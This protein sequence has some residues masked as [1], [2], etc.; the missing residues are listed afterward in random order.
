MDHRL[1]SG[2][3]DYTRFLVVGAARTG[4]NLVTQSLNAHPEVACFR[5][6]F[7]C[8]P[9]TIEFGQLGYYHKQNAHSMIDLKQNDPLRLVEQEV[10]RLF[11]KQIKA[12]GYKLL[13]NHACEGRM[14]DIR[15]AIKED[16]SLRV[17]HLK[18]RDALA[19]ILSAKL[20]IEQKKWYVTHKEIS[21]FKQKPIRLSVDFCRE[22]FEFIEDKTMEHDELFAQHDVLE[23]EYETLSSEFV[24]TM[25][26]VQE[27]L[28]ITQKPLSQ[29]TKKMTAQS[30]QEL[31]IN[32]DELKSAFAATKWS[33]YFVE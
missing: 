33:M 16:H 8:D 27:F 25:N 4:T 24:K 11:G 14:S 2:H 29:H 10:F 28:G 18:R 19:K 21:L 5:E 3:R 31:I 20:A 22:R 1:R 17:I 6:I 12:V 9:Q 26:Q 7:H 30:P 13:Y 32:Y 15:T 23:I